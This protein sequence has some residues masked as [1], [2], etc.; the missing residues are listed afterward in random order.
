MTNKSD[1]CNSPA[2][3]WKATN[4]PDFWLCRECLQPC[5]LIEDDKDEE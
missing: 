4:G 2:V 1:C 5:E 3:K